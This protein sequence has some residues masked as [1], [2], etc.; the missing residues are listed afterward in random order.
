VYSNVSLDVCLN[1]YDKK[2]N[3]KIIKTPKNKTEK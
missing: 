3:V 2:D 1:C